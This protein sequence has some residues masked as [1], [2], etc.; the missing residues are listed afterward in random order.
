MPRSALLP[1]TVHHF[2][3]R[4][5]LAQVPAVT[6]VRLDIYPD[7]GVNRVRLTGEVAPESLRAM[8]EGW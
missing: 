4:D 7:G 8:L 2:R 5:L 1:D 3:L 6:H